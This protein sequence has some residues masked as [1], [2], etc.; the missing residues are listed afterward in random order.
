M[1]YVDVGARA[2]DPIAV[3]QTESL[4]GYKLE[5]NAPERSRAYSSL[6]APFRG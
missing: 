2:T 6:L 1:T 5:I 3:V 4:R